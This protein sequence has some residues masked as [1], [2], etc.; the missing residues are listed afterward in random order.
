MKRYQECGFG[1]E[2]DFWKENTTKD[3]LEKVWKTLC[4][5]KM[6]SLQKVLIIF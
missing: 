1:S 2:E 3:V 5:I 6:L 4:L